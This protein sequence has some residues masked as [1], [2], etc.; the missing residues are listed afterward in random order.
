MRPTPGIVK[1][2]HDPVPLNRPIG[3]ARITAIVVRM[4]VLIWH[5]EKRSLLV[6]RGEGCAIGAVVVV[7]TVYAASQELHDPPAVT[8]ERLI[9]HE[10]ELQGLSRL[11]V[12][13]E[14]AAV[15]REH[16]R[17]MLSVGRIFHES[18]TTGTSADRLDRLPILYFSCGENVGAGIGPESLHAKLMGSPEHR[19]NILDSGFTHVGVGTAGTDDNLYVTELFARIIPV[20]EPAEL[21]REVALRLRETRDRLCL[22]PIPEDRSLAWDARG[23]A[24]EMLAADATK[25][26]ESAVRPPSG[27]IR[28]LSFVG[29]QPRWDIIDE[30]AAGVWEAYG[31]GAAQ[32]KS[33][34]QS[35]GA[36]WYVILLWRQS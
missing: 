4:R 23:L 6:R 9:N 25:P 24:A 28:I 7:C 26:D 5:H 2:P 11:E 20:A 21:E 3:S 10:R 22:Q 17:E 16:S 35:G 36:N 31:I 8:V 34:S 27:R 30:E 18:P 29:E 1:H 13:A 12:S 33:P 14:L 15:A 19:R 32:G